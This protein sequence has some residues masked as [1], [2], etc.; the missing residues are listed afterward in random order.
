MSGEEATY[1]VEAARGAFPGLELR[2]SD[3][4]SSYAGVRPVV[5]TGAADPSK[6]SREHVIWNERGL[7]TVTGGKLTTFR[8]IARDALRALEHAQPSLRRRVDEGRRFFGSVAA[9]P[10]RLDA[11]TRRRLEGRYGPWANALCRAAGEGELKR[12]SDT[13]T[14]WAELR[15]AARAERVV[16][17]EDLLLRRVRLG[18]VLPEGGREQLPRVRA[19]CQEELGWDDRR[20]AEEEERYLDA[21]Q[22]HHKAPP[23]AA[24][25]SAP[26]SPVR[27]AAPALRPR[28]HGLQ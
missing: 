6:E 7:L 11:L 26:V 15:W 12:V 18:L 8:T 5:G 9:I 19:V 13:Y 3:A 16:H 17:L 21:W 28:E 25:A 14:V 22:R 1:L 10:T 4:V 24:K 2:V 27:A 20:W 23:V